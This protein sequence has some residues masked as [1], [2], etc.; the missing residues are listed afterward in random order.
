V[1]GRTPLGVPVAAS[2]L[3]EQDR[4]DL[5]DPPFLPP[6]DDGLAVTRD[7]VISLLNYDPETGLFRWRVDRGRTAKVGWVAG[8]IDSSGHRQIMIRGRGYAAH[9]LA[10]LIVHGEMPDAEVDHR[11]GER[12][13]NRIANLRLAS[14]LEQAANRRPR[15]RSRYKGVTF[16][17]RQR[18]WHAA[19]GGTKTRTHLGTFDTEEDAAAA[20]EA[21]ARVRYGEFARCV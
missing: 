6:V 9:R 21:A 1:T 12:D 19:I 16:H 7:E 15:G 10:W 18:K 4:A 3:T 20:Y 2:A 17:R 11:N 5:L 8:S 14:D 13:D